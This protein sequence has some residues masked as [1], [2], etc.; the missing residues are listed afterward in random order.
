M[1]IIKVRGININYD[2]LGE[3]GSWVVLVGGG[4]GPMEGTRPMAEL[5]AA[6]GYRILILDRRNCGK[7]DVGITGGASEFDEWADDL[8]EL[9]KQL[10]AQPC[11]VGGASS[12][13]RT[14]IAY[15]IRHPEAVSGLLLWKMSG[16]AYAAMNLGVRYY[17]E[18]IK[19]AGL[20]GMEAV[21]ETEFFAGR[22]AGNQRNRDIL[23]AMD[24][25][26]FIKVML[27]WMISFISGATQPVIGAS[28]EDLKNIKVPVLLFRG[29]DR[30]HSREVSINV[31]NLIK[32]CELVDLGLPVL[33]VDA[34]PPSEMEK[35]TPEMVD[36]FDEF[37]KRRIMMTD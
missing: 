22:I 37:L 3:K 2:T 4:R 11:V 18:Y 21:C 35:Y 34:A 14:S 28:E 8:F 13:C 20:G 17:N 26:D 23:M 10:G 12:G 33:D 6:K 9:T 25:K 5:M 16:G 31:K 36:K 7:S 32:D 24:P 30:H 27:R 1:P 19:A 29:N 15:A